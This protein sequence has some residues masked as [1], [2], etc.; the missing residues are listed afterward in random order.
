MYDNLAAEINDTIL[1][2]TNLNPK[3][4]I[5]CT[6]ESLITDAEIACTI[7]SRPRELFDFCPFV[8]GRF[9][10]L[11]SGLVCVFVFLLRYVTLASPNN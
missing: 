11:L 7:D 3:K 5:A 6:I 4:M 1:D 2:R 10:S 9:C 8:N